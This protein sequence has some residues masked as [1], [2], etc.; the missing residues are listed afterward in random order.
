MSPAYELYSPCEMFFLLSFGKVTAM[1][2]LI[3]IKRNN[4]ISNRITLLCRVIFIYTVPGMNNVSQEISFLGTQ[5]S[6]IFGSISGKLLY[7]SWCFFLKREQNHLIPI[8]ML[9][10]WNKSVKQNKMKNHPLRNH[11]F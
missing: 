5:F 11:F 4:D 8:V 10:L 9:M 2:V 3:Y 6:S 1:Y 7:E